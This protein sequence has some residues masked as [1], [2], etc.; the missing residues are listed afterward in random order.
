MFA[1]ERISIGT[2]WFDAMTLNG[3][4]NLRT[5]IFRLSGQIFLA[6]ADLPSRDHPR[7]IRRPPTTKPRAHGR[8]YTVPDKPM[9]ELH[10]DDDDEGPDDYYETLSEVDDDAVIA[11]AQRDYEYSSAYYNNMA[12]MC[13][14]ISP[15]VEVFFS[16]LL[17]H[18][19]PAS[20]SR[21]DESGGR[22]VLVSLISYSN[23]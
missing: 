12:F 21:L 6:R 13:R 4:S 17:Q 23:G 18:L 7:T 15:S 5:I 3:Y 20:V 9:A 1:L 16:F 22:Q 14:G 10:V 8:V 2:P 19:D 11:Y